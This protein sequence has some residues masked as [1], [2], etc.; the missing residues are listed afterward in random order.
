MTRTNEFFENFP[1]QIFLSVMFVLLCLSAVAG[2]KVVASRGQYLLGRTDNI[3]NPRSRTDQQAIA[4]M[5]PIIQE[6]IRTGG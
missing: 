2:G 5:V 3:G 6:C 4:G 1:Q